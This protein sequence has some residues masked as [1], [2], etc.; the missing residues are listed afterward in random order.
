WQTLQIPARLHADRGI[1]VQ[2]RL[3]PQRTGQR[4]HCAVVRAE[5]QAREIHLEAVVFRGLREALAQR[6][7]CADAAGDDQPPTAGLFQ[8]APALDH[9]RVDDRVFE[10]ARDVGFCGRIGG[11]FLVGEQYL[12]LQAA[13][14]EV[15]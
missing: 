9:E 10:R 13:E 3:Q 7:I 15:E 1:V 12:G 2:P 8:R 14:T 11:V 5:F 6:A 4:D